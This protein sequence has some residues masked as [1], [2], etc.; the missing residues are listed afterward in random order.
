LVGRSLDSK[1]DSRAPKVVIVNQKFAQ[2]Y[3]PNENIIGKRFT[4]DS[5]KP[6]EIEIVG[7]TQDAKYTSQ[8]DET[9]P[10]VY[11]PWQQSLRAMQMS[12]FELRT[13]GDP[14]AYVTAVREAVREID[15]NLP[16][17]SMKTQVEQANETLSMER[18]FA[19]LLSLFGILALLLAAVGLYGVMAY[20]VS[21]RTHEIGVRMAL[22]AT[23][24]TVMQMVL[25]QGMFLT[26]I[27][28]AVGL[29][30]AYV[31]TKYLETLTTML[32]GVEP[33]DPVTFS[34]I[35]LFLAVIAFLACL[36]P[37]RRA[38]K[39]DPLVALRYE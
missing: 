4:F 20:S 9:E 6:G 3:F 33:R 14:A 5:S 22:G 35:A 38:T 11:V 16:I 10:T 37:A 29:A 34:A 12:T 17:S 28:I 1:D 18:L 2:S 7:L 15:S 24:R 8:R 19:K 30:G 36:I 26:V 25:S 23:R 13:Q 27:G 21:Q 39:V 31:L 32:F